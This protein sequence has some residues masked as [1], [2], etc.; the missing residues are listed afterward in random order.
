MRGLDIRLVITRPDD[1]ALRSKAPIGS[2]ASS[3]TVG[4]VIEASTE[5]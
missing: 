1:A 5:Y 3:M 4:E 2:G